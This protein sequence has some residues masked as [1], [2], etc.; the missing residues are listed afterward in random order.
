M[1]RSNV[2]LMSNRHPQNPNPE[3]LNAVWK[4]V[5]KLE[6]DFESLLNAINAPSFWSKLW[7]ERAW[8]IPTTLALLGLLGS[9]V[10]YVGRLILENHVRSALGSIHQEI[11]DVKATLSAIQL[12]QLS[13]TPTTPGSLAEVK[14]VLATAKSNK[15]PIG[16][17]ALASA[18]KQFMDAAKTNASA[19]EA[20]LAVI[21]YKS[22]L[23]ASAPTFMQLENLPKTLSTRYVLPIVTGH[24]HESSVGVRGVAPKE[25]AARLN[26]IGQ[27]D[28]ANLAQGDQ[29]IFVS[30]GQILIDDMDL[31]NVVFRGVKIF[32]Q[33]GP[34]MM[35]NV[36]FVNCTFV[37]IQKP[38]GESFA[39]AILN[40][41]PEVTAKI[42]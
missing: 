32:Y 39:T 12:K 33:G 11:Q 4:A 1:R 25:Q 41:N 23:N 37:I 40:G 20:A 8:L 42:A 27:D 3:G 30:G 18:G 15:I 29:I 2:L 5:H 28:N 14:T 35:E 7:G 34:I 16:S 36:F 13:S 21:D 10:W 38:K 24:E 6:K 19:W 31:K 26:H 17:D 9:G 22:F